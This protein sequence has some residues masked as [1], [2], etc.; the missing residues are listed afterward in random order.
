MSS[1]ESMK[2]RNKL[3]TFFKTIPEYK[4][5]PEDFQLNAKH[6]HKIYSV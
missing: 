1:E 4:L 3:D 2:V 5:A 6:N